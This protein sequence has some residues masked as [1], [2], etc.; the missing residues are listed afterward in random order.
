[1][2]EIE[3]TVTKTYRFKHIKEE[4]EEFTDAVKKG[5]DPKDPLACMKM[6]MASI[7][8]DGI[9]YEDLVTTENEVGPQGVEK[10]TWTLIHSEGD[11]PYQVT[12]VQSF[13]WSKENEA[14]YE[15]PSALEDNNFDKHVFDATQITE[16]TDA[17]DKIADYKNS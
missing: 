15:V 8:K 5:L 2:D 1:M 10:V 4:Y 7:Y 16:V 17:D 6:D 13:R 14:P 12:Q 9:D 3:V 11:D